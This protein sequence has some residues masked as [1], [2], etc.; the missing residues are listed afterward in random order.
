MSISTADE[1]SAVVAAQYPHGVRGRVAA[2]KRSGPREDQSAFDYASL[3]EAVLA[4]V[5]LVEVQGVAVAS[6]DRQLPVLAIA[7]GVTDALKNQ[8]AF[9]E[10]FVVVI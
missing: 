10:V 3:R 7:D 4:A 6:Q 8:V 1:F 5:D 9:L 2:R